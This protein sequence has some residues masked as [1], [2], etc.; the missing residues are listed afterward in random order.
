MKKLFFILP[1]LLLFQTAYCDVIPP[2]SHR[3]G[4]CV[5]ITNIKD[6][7]DY[8]IVLFSLDAMEGRNESSLVNP[9]D[10][11]K[12]V[13]RYNRPYIVAA[14]KSYLEGK[15]LDSID[16]LHDKNVLQSNIDV[17]TYEAIVSNDT[18][19]AAVEEYYKIITITQTELI[20]YKYKEIVNFNDGSPISVKT[21]PRI[22]TKINNGQI[23]GIY[24]SRMV[25]DFLTA[26]LLT[27]FIETLI[28]FLLF[29]TKYKNLNIQKQ[30]L[31][32]TGI[33][34]SFLTL[35]YVWFVFPAFIHS[36]FPYIITS[37]VFA[38]MIESVIICKLLKIEYKKAF[39][40]SLLCNVISF[41]IGLMMNYG[42]SM[43]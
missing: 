11:I 37:E 36:Q 39:W 30:Q 31:L 28:L 19:V 22:E 32:F 15:V 16:W 23:D 34:A 14:K 20:L 4:K 33:I 24:P 6:F 38:V 42:I 5:K 13:Y 7:P 25:L 29:K 40:I 21:Y 3:V 27:I 43:I 12:R 41:S 26:L 35:P 17:D 9:Y 1:F 18:A 10:C 8:R 2:N